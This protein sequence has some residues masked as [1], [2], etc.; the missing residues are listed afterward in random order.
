MTRYA[1]LFVSGL[2]LSVPAFAVWQEPVNIGSV[3]NTQYNDWYPVLSRDGSY[4][5][6]VSDR[7]TGYGGADLWI[8]YRDAEGWQTP[9]NLGPGV[10]T[11]QIESAPFLASGDSMLYFASFAPGGQGS[12]DI[13][14]CSLNNGVPGL[15]TNLGSPVNGGALDCC[16]VLSPD[17]TKLYICSTRAGGYG[18]MDVWCS[19]RAGD[20]WGVPYNVGTNLNSDRTDCPRWISDDGNTL[21]VC[22]TRT[23]GLGDADVW[24]SE[25]DGQGWSA[26]VN[27]GTPINT[28]WA[29]W[30][31]GFEDNEGTI[32]G[33]MFFG[34]GRGGGQG[35]WDIWYSTEAPVSAEEQAALRSICPLQTCPNPVTSQ[36]AVSYSLTEPGRVVV[37]VYDVQGRL[38]RTLIDQEQDPGQYTATWNLTTESGQSVSEGVCYCRMKAGKESATQKVVVTK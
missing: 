1:V 13:W 38:I 11:F 29:E 35:G 16:P 4:M 17:G 3:I 7:P 25:N 2:C 21:I 37:G 9:Q 6:F 10:N 31:V 14:A 24:Y 23:D 34:S 30:G 36:T 28:G 32:G 26:V 15:K 8:S 27:L 5:I 20:E 12:M 18:Q 22:S 19:E 33:T